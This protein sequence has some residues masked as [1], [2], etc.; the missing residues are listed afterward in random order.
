MSLILFHT[1]NRRAG[2]TYAERASNTKQN[3]NGA[4]YNVDNT[5]TKK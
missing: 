5:V 2:V 3:I 1:S 4:V